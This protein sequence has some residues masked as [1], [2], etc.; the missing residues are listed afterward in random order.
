[1][2]LLLAIFYKGMIEKLKFKKLN[3]I[4]NCDLANKYV[5]SNVFNI[6][7]IS[8]ITIQLSLQDIISFND[9]LTVPFKDKDY[10][11][12]SFL[13]LFFYFLNIPF[14]KVKK[15]IESRFKIE[16]KKFSKSFF[17]FSCSNKTFLENFIF[18]L[19]VE[20]QVL[21]TNQNKNSLSKFLV[22]KA[23]N[24][25]YCI[26]HFLVVAKTFESFDRVGI[27]IFN[28]TNIKQINFKLMIQIYKPN[29]FFNVKTMIQNLPFFWING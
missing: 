2:L 5:I 16:T 24:I 22:T 25:Q 23:S 12:K 15:I 6:P 17:Q 21:N 14:Y 18:N 7:K 8:D 20:N 28:D 10:K 4:F 19:F 9:S 29:F 13:L 11:I 26:F 3:Y 1:M 27:S